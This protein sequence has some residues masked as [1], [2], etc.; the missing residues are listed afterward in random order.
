MTFKDIIEKMKLH[1]QTG[2][3]EAFVHVGDKGDL[4]DYQRFVNMTAEYVDVYMYPIRFGFKLN[5]DNIV[6]MHQFFTSL[7][8]EE[9]NICLYISFTPNHYEEFISKIEMHLDDF[10]KQPA[11]MTEEYH[12]D[13][14]NFID[15]LKEKRFV[16]KEMRN[17][18]HNNGL[19]FE[20]NRSMFTN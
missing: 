8:I 6:L 20:F 2:I 9:D 17:C 1:D 5:G 16:A 10:A 19:Y 11:D 14:D 12:K 4:Y 18:F 7:V 13:I 3:I 15:I